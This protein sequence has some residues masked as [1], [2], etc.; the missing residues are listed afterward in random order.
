MRVDFQVVR[1]QVGRTVRC[2]SC[3]KTRRKIF[4]GE[5]TYNPFNKGDPPTQAQADAEQQAEMAGAE[6]ICQ[7]CGDA[8]NREALVAF[9]NGA[10]LPDQQWG[11]P[12]HVLLERGNIEEVHDNS[13][14]PQCAQGQ[15]RIIGYRLTAK[16]QRIADK[17]RAQ[18]DA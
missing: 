8:P 4:T 10:P 3:S 1:R 12:T 11:N 2:P 13:P 15:W 9:A 7:R 17:E 6:V 14:C 5:A 18:G 16:G